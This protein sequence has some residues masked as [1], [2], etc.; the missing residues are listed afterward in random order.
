[1]KASFLPDSLNFGSRQQHIYFIDYSKNVIENLASVL[2]VF[3]AKNPIYLI[4][5]TLPFAIIILYFIYSVWRNDKIS[6]F[7]ILIM[8]CY[9]IQLMIMHWSERRLFICL[10]PLFILLI[11]TVINNIGHKYKY[12]SI[13]LVLSVLGCYFAGI[14]KIIS[15]DYCSPTASIVKYLKS[16]YKAS[17][18]ILFH[19]SYFQVPFDYYCSQFDFHPERQ[20]FPL[21]IYEWWR[22]QP[23]KGWGA[24][25]L[26]K[27]E[28][29]E[30]VNKLHENRRG[31][32]IWLVLFETSYFDTYGQLLFKLK[33]VSKEISEVNIYFGKCDDEVDM[34]KKYRV[35]SL[36]L[37][38]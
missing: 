17:D 8:T 14:I 21:S 36:T 38:D 22:Q 19:S 6:R 7:L 33:E 9:V 12:L 35:F 34:R 30:Y 11:G 23:L 15:K 2:G 27:A 32:R 13:F 24:P 5:L 18:M 16:N 20:G 29:E 37:N 1:V 3:P 31:K 26:S 25:V 10:A 4:L 28:L